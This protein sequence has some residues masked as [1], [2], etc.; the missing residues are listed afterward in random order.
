MIDGTSNTL[1]VFLVYKIR[2]IKMLILIRTGGVNKRSL[3]L[4]AVRI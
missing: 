1:G 4:H 2:I 3:N